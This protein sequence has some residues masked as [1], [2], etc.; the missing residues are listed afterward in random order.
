MELPI[1]DPQPC[2]GK[3]KESLW[4][5]PNW[6]AEHKYHGCRYLLYSDGRL[7]SRCPSVNGTGYVN[8]IDRVPHLAEAVLSLPPGT[9]IDGE[10]VASDFGTVRDVTSIL[11]SSPELAILKQ[12]ERGRLRFKAFDLPFLRNVDIRQDT[13]AVRRQYLEQLF[14][15]IFP[16]FIDLAKVAYTDKKAFCNNIFE[17]GGEGII[18]KYQG[19]KYGEKKYWVKVKAVE[20]YDVFVLGYKEANEVSTK[21]DGTVSQTKYAQENWIG[22]VEMGMMDVITGLPVSVGFCSGFDEALR[23]NISMNKSN[24]IGRTFEIKAQ[25]QLK[26]GK[27]E[28]P[29]FIRWRD[30]K[31]KDACIL[32]PEVE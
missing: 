8:K 10:I 20:T 3:M 1:I 18:L 16:L 24:Y 28:H 7:L 30:D 23:N 5:D 12:E 15:G 6:W 27:F 26:S 21:V 9:V 25:S 17:K 31:S 2:R 11:G 13:L 32:F 4:E 22:A 14:G 19:A 29:R